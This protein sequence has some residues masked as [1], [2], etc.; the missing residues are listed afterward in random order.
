MH[1]TEPP[2]WQVGRF[3][4]Y[5]RLRDREISLRIRQNGRAKARVDGQRIH[6]E[7]DHD[8]LMIG[9]HNY[10]LSKTRRGF[11]AESTVDGGYRAIRFR[12]VY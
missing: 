3:K 12:R 10:V 8:L 5:D 2:P 7:L 11:I 4:G 9:R 6:A 1:I